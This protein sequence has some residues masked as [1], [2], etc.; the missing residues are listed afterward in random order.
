MGGGGK[1]AL[2]LTL[3]VCAALPSRP[4]AA[5]RLHNRESRIYLLLFSLFS[6]LS[7]FCNISWTSADLAMCIFLLVWVVVVQTLTSIHTQNVHWVFG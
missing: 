1:D 3:G 7:L 5:C 4:G 2:H 6:L